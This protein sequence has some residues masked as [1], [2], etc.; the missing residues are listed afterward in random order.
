MCPTANSYNGA[1]QGI[2]T[3]MLEGCLAGSA[4]P[5]VMSCCWSVALCVAHKEAALPGDS[6]MITAASR[7]RLTRRFALPL[8]EHVTALVQV[9]RDGRFMKYVDQQLWRNPDPLDERFQQRIVSLAGATQAQKMP[10]VVQSYSEQVCTVLCADC[11]TCG[12]VTEFAALVTSWLL[13]AGDLAF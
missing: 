1:L 4:G 5:C 7:S 3:S 10:A 11:Q 13:S 6:D 12:M 9:E 8:H 2:L